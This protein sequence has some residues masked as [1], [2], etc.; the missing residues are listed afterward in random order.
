M[1]TII[2]HV[3]IIA[4]FIIH[5]PQAICQDNDNYE[6]CG[7]LISC[8]SV[9]NVGYPFFGE[10]RP[11]KCGYPG[12]RLTCESGIP[13]IKIEGLTYRVLGI[14]DAG[15]ILS[16]SREDLYS[17]L[18]PSLLFNTSLDLNIFHY[19][20]VQQ[21]VTL[22]YGCSQIPGQIK[23]LSENQFE[24]DNVTRT[25]SLG[26]Y[27][28]SQ[29]LASNFSSN[30]NCDASIS[31]PVNLALAQN[32]TNLISSADELREVLASGFQVQWSASNEICE[33][34]SLSGGRC[35]YNSSLS[36][37]V[38]YSKAGSGGIRPVIIAIIASLGSI[39]AITIMLIIAFYCGRR[40]GS[41]VLYISKMWKG[42]NQNLKAFIQRCGSRTPKQFNYSE[43]KEITN[44]F[45][46]KLGQGGYGSVFKG[47][48]SDGR[49]VAVKIL[50]EG[51]GNG[52]DFIN[53][54]AS[55]VRTSHPHVVA[56]LGSCFDQKRALIYEFMP[57]GSLDRSLVEDCML[58]WNTL[59]NIALGTAKGLDYL[60]RDCNPQILHF[61]IKPQNILLD[62]EYCPKI[63]DFGLARLAER[64]LTVLPIQ[65]AGGTAG[66][67]AP[68]VF[69]HAYGGVSDK[70]D[71]YSYGMMILG[72]VGA[73]R[74]NAIVVDRSTQK[75]FPNWIYD[76]L[77]FGKE[78][79][80]RVVKDEEE[81]QLARKLIIVG[82]S[83]IQTNPDD[84][85]SMYE[86]VK[87][88]ESDSKLLQVPPR[89]KPFLSTPF[90]V[91]QEYSS[92]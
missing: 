85:P 18:C 61:D 34:C 76:H 63:S 53:E 32:L 57:N 71:V 19:G 3:I 89:P 66:Y 40:R 6:S 70:S 26:F 38:C 8:G 77:E 29:G 11:E 43:I 22:F 59:Y 45:S 12:F 9:Q 31:V 16:I 20:V 51:K 50:S 47:T 87:M 79:E 81:Q 37:I 56:L 60:H 88:L 33:E 80:T 17:N 30:M 52:D 46:E 39:G 10:G 2:S 91:Q 41:L 69:M 21:N 92:T 72:T 64:Q 15:K 73:T 27:L 25:K 83:C 5:I 7:K 54:V 78:I 36:S 48:L 90:K 14:D 44:G 86:I 13:F 28:T 24:C 74:N 42:K 67:I 75:Y 58:E 23:S 35:G 49:H 65:N 68:E 62:K 82:L 84:R 55:L 4:L 1:L